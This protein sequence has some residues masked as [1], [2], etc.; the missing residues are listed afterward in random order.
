MSL[1]IIHDIAAAMFWG[2]QQDKAHLP[3]WTR[4]IVLV[5]VVLRISVNVILNIEKKR[6][7][8][9]SWNSTEYEQFDK[10]SGN[11]NVRQ[12][13]FMSNILKL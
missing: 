13:V 12:N 6:N 8:A 2:V 5:F 10:D 4:W 11:A 1:V 7:S 3:K 9:Q